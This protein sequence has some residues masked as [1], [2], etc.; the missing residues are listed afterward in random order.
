MG[1]LSKKS[2]F[3]VSLLRAGRWVAA[4]SLF[5]CGGGVVHGG[6][7]LTAESC[8]IVAGG[9]Q[10]SFVPPKPPRRQWCNIMRNPSFELGLKDWVPYRP[11][12]ASVEIVK[13]RRATSFI[14]DRALSADEFS[15]RFAGK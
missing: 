10:K 1:S 13:L 14:L 9:E 3:I 5:V 4:F 15:R 6:P 11:M 2:G 12:D 8:Q 7:S